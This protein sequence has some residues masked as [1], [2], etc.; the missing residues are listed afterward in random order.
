MTCNTEWHGGSSTGIG[1]SFFRGFQ[2]D[3]PGVSTVHEQ[4]RYKQNFY[5]R[6]QEKKLVCVKKKLYASNN[7]I[8]YWS[9]GNRNDFLTRRSIPFLQRW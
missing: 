1:A 4:N 2:S 3:K 7:R 9:H 5:S 8:A 6:A